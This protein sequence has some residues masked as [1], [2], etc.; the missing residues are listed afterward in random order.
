[1]G[2]SDWLTRNYVIRQTGKDGHGRVVGIKVRPRFV[3]P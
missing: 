1:M 2:A 3:L